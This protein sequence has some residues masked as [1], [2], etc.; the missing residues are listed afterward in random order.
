MS[1]TERLNDATPFIVQSPAGRR[2]LTFALL[3]DREILVNRSPSS[4]VQTTTVHFECWTLG[5][6]S[7]AVACSKLKLVSYYKMAVDSA[8]ERNACRIE[9]ETRSTQTLTPDAKQFKVIG[10]GA[11]GEVRLVQKVD[12]GKVY[13]MKSLQKAEMLKRGQVIDFFLVGSTNL[14]SIFLSANGPDAIKAE[15]AGG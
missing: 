13:A 10:K 9:L 3:N 1:D 8:M 4:S 14:N 11:S 15:G 2:E 5:F 7:E 6:S 12:T